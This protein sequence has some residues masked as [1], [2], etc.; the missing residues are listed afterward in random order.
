MT[1]LMM[2]M[3]ARTGPTT[4]SSPSSSSTI[5]WGSMSEK[6]TGSENGLVEYT[7][8]KKQQTTNNE[9]DERIKMES[10]KEK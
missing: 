2:K 4:Q 3:T 5:G 6:A 8:Y 9:E 7:V 10:A 1:M